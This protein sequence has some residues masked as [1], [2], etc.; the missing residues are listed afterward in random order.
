MMARSRCAGIRMDSDLYRR[1]LA[2]ISANHPR[3]CFGYFITKVDAC[4][5]TDFLLL[6]DNIRNDRAWQ[7]RFHAYGRY[8][9][10]HDDA[11]F[12]ATPEET[13]RVQKEIWKRDMFEVGIFHSHQRHPGNFSQIDYVLHLE[14]YIGLWHLIISQRN[15]KMP[16]V[17]IF[18]VSANGV[19]E[20]PL[21]VTGSLLCVT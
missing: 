20:L 5:P 13:W 21:T 2:T 11:G 16:Q 9:V 8:F 10:D 17:R 1:F 4:V 19:R 3:K 14:R 7:P 12:V 6:H 15:P 18:D